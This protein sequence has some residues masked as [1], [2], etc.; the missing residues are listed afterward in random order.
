MVSVLENW[1]DRCVSVLAEIEG[2]VRDVRRKAMESRRREE[3]HAKAV[4]KAMYDGEKKG[5]KR[6]GEEEEIEY[7]DENTGRKT[8]G[9]K[10]GGGNIFNGIGKRLGGS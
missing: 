6:G 7:M 9:A 10:R 1:D 8:R 5:G 3:A 4:E 2:Q